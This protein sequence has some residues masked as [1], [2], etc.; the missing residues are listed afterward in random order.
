MWT[1]N[2][3]TVADLVLAPFDSEQPLTRAE[4][5][6]QVF[7]YAVFNAGDLRLEITYQ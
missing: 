7:Y 2:P 1:S 4:A 3:I 6:D 5:R